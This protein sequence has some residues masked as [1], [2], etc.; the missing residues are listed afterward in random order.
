MTVVRDSAAD[1]YGL[2]RSGKR[3]AGG[4][5]VRRWE[6]RAANRNQGEGEGD[7]HHSRSDK[8]SQPEARDGKGEGDDAQNRLRGRQHDS[9]SEGTRPSQRDDQR[10][11]SRQIPDPALALL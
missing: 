4:L 8:Q 2:T 7:G 10:W 11:V 6:L 1:R 3:A 5:K 9:S